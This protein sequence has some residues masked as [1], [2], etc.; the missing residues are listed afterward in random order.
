M[1]RESLLAFYSNAIA[2]FESK[3][4]RKLD[5]VSFTAQKPVEDVPRLLQVFEPKS[6][7]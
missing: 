3:V 6:P 5:C 4:Y 7:K 2:A 1:L